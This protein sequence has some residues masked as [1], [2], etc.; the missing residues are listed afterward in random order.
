MPEGALSLFEYIC[1]ISCKFK[2]HNVDVAHGISITKIR[3]TKELYCSA[4][5]LQD[6]LFRVLTKTVRKMTFYKYLS[7]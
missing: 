2:I 6:V 3:I 5:R 4:Y 7:K 1:G